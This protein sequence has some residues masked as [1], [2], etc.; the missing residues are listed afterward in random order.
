M[1]MSVGSVVSEDAISRLR[2]SGLLKT[3]GLINGDWIDA[4][5]GKTFEVVPIIS[6]A[7]I[8]DDLLFYC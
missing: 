3:Q 1:Q 4:Y 6:L 2:D 5:D 8:L 7:C